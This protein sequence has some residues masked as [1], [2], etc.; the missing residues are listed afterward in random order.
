MGCASVTGFQRVRSILVFRKRVVLRDTPKYVWVDD[1]FGESFDV[2]AVPG[3][4][5]DWRGGIRTRSTRS[6]TFTAYWF[7]EM[8][9]A[10]VPMSTAGR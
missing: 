4:A 1:I 5:T 6:S 9:W 8:C 3:Q 2:L 7:N 10:A